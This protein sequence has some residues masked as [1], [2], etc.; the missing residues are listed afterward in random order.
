M[1]SF[2]T[3]I[4]D[5][6]LDEDIPVTV[7]ITSVSLGCKATYWEPGEDPEVEIAVYAEG[8]DKDIFDTLGPYAQ[9]RLVDEAWEYL[10]RQRDDY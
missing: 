6:D 5:E 3:T 10:E 8:S 2:E 1:R 9:E 4:Y 7:E